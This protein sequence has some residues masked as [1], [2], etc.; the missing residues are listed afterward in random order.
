MFEALDEMIDYVDENA[1]TDNRHILV[2][3]HRTDNS[4]EIHVD[5][6]I[7]KAIEKNVKIDFIWYKDEDPFSWTMAKIVHKTGGGSIYIDHFFR[8]NAAFLALDRII[9]G[10][11]GYFKVSARRIAPPETFFEGY[12]FGNLVWVSGFS[13]VVFYLDL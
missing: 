2:F 11:F 4:A 13:Y 3:A 12:Y 5:S 6:T 8:F 10:E 1:S 9:K 7:A